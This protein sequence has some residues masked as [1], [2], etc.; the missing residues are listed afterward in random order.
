MTF[1]TSPLGSK[2]TGTPEDSFSASFKTIPS[3]TTALAKIEKFALQEYMGEQHYQVEWV[4]TDGDYKGRHIFQK[5]HAFDKDSTRRHRF[6]NML[7]LIYNMFHVKPKDANPPQDDELRVFI[8]KHAG[9]LIEEWEKDGRSGNWVS[10]IH[11]V[12][13]FKS[14]TGVSVETSFSHESGGVDS[15]FDRYNSSKDA[16]ATEDDVPF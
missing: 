15:A 4:L 2:L 1:W 11:P 7:M 14:I 6:L 16:V 13:G 9:I 12:D 10:E 8:G 5:I 3:G